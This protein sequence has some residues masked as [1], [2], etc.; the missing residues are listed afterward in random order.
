MSESFEIHELDRFT[1]GAIGE[2]GSRLFLMQANAG[3]EVITLK[4]EKQHVAAIALEL[5]EMLQTLPRPGHLP[6]DLDLIEPYDIAWAVSGLKA[7]WHEAADRVVLQ[8]FEFEPDALTGIDP[9][10]PDEVIEALENTTPSATA[11][12]SLTREQA[13]AL[14]IRCRLLVEA[15]R[16]PCP[17][18][19]YPLEPDHACPRT[20]G[21]RPPNT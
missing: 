14:S 8:A 20:N 17:L 19:G 13:G 11:K 4:L 12:F 16:P 7:I 6:E 21:N 15:G 10:S 1:V 9:D 5:G 18:C 3:A 2:P